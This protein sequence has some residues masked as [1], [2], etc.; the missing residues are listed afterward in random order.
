MVGTDQ[1]GFVLVDNGAKVDEGSFHSSANKL[2]NIAYAKQPD[3]YFLLISNKLYKKKLNSH[4]PEEWVS[5][6]LGW[7][8]HTPLIYAEKQNRIWTVKGTKS[9]AVINPDQKGIEFEL[10]IPNVSW[11]MDYVIFG[12]KDQYVALIANSHFLVLIEYD[13]EKKRGKVLTQQHVTIPGCNTG[14]NLAIDSM[15]KVI[16]VT[17]KQWVNS[18]LLTPVLAL[19][20]YGVGD[21]P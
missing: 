7:S 6:G 12:E 16:M 4:S 20:S 18:K 11:I 2:W 19:L 3:C 8:V 10:Q 21:L 5:G 9:I 13:V 14:Y 1:K 15:S 17:S